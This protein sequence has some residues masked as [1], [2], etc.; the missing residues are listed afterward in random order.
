[1]KKSLLL[2]LLVAVFLPRTQCQ[3]VTGSGTPDYIP[4]WITG[5]GGGNDDSPTSIIGTSNIYQAS[6]RIA[7]NHTGPVDRFHVLGNGVFEE[8]AYPRKHYTRLVCGHDPDL[9]VNS[10]NTIG[11]FGFNAHQTGNGYWYRKGD[12]TYNGGS[13][14]WGN[15]KGDLGFSLISSTGGSDPSAISTN[16]VASNVKMTL[17]SKGRIGLG[18]VVPG[19]NLEI[20]NRENNKY[21]II[22]NQKSD[23]TRSMEIRFDC[24][25]TELWALGHWDM[26]AD[27]TLNTFFIWNNKR[28][29]CAFTVHGGTGWVGIKQPWPSATLDVNGSFEASQIGIGTYPPASG[30]PW[31]LFVDG[32]I[33]ARE[34]KVTVS[35]FADYV[36]KDSYPLLSIGDL[37]AYV[38][39][40]NHL[41]GIPSSEEVKTNEGIELG[42][43]QIKLLEKIEEQALYIIS[44]QKQL[45]ELKA[46]VLINKEEK[47]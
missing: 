31:K 33:K 6:G 21:G 47:R 40:N 18:T 25:K 9:S 15:T 26:N 45:D 20:I 44:L 7:I 16:D 13:L 24:N 17:T 14:I 23:S 4:I 41:P 19:G 10:S 39:E 28:K 30:S 37:A 46:L 43:M 12:G 35:S 11:Y 34:I 5:G 38:K 3:T 2:L 29:E 22:L 32:G 8:E 27:T 1:M 36:F 42:T